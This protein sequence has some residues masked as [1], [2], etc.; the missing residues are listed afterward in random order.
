M[1]SNP[2]FD[3]F[4][5]ICAELSGKP[6]TIL[7]D[8]DFSPAMLEGLRRWAGE[9]ATMAAVAKALD[10]L[11]EHF[12]TRGAILPFEYD[13]ATGHVTTLN[14]EYVDFVAE[15]QDKRS[16]AKESRGFEIAT[17][18]HIAD[19]LTGIVR[20]VGSPRTKHKKRKQ[21]ATYLASEFGFRDNVLVGLDKD[22]GFD[23]L[24]FPPLGAFPFRAMVSIQCKNSLYDRGDGLESVGRAK[25]CLSRHS[26][27][28]AE[29]GHLHCVVYNDYIDEKIMAH[30]RDVGFIPL[31]LSDLA[32]LTTPISLEQL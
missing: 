9:A 31:G 30:A 10:Y 21:F 1:A 27:N 13:L 8:D 22:G 24:W 11:H 6:E 2:A 29:E 16:R 19:K 18:K 4:E 7:I 14:G 20:R 32:P 17:S 26:H 25:Q 3:L 28:S 23:I 12:L 5:E 15:A